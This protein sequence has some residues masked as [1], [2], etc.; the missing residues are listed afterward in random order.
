MI[1]DRDRRLFRACTRLA[2]AYRLLQSAGHDAGAVRPDLE[3]V[4]ER[5]ARSLL[6]LVRELR[7]EMDREL[8]EWEAEPDV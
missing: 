6:W 8:I 3:P 7:R 2:D 4:I 5:N 1:T